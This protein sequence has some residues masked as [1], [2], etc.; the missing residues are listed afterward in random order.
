ME[1]ARYKCLIIII[2]II[3]IIIMSK[4]YVVCFRDVV[5]TA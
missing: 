1:L 2:I 4:Y 5:W 3:I